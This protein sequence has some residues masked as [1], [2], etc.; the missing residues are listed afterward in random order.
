MAG[1]IVVFTHP[2]IDR[3]L[4]WG[5][6]S[7][8]FPAVM[9]STSILYR[10]NYL[11]HKKI[12]RSKKHTITI[13]LPPS[14][15]IIHAEQIQGMPARRSTWRCPWHARRNHRKPVH[16]SHSE[17]HSDLNEHTKA[18]RTMICS[19]VST[20]MTPSSFSLHPGCLPKPAGIPNH[21]QKNFSVPIISTSSV[22]RTELST[23]HA[24]A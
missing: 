22:T 14:H 17:S 1:V 8:Y 12:K 20:P 3:L 5:L 11:L 23:P 13:N 15:N 9:F 16:R 2:Q 18:T 7:M 10:L 4:C 6:V 19:P 21:T 24:N